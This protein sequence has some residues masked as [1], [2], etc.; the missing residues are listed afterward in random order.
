ML[1]LG[2]KLA[3]IFLLFFWETFSKFEGDCNCEVAAILNLLAFFLGRLMK[4]GD[5]PCFS[6]LL[7]LSSRIMFTVFL[8]LIDC[9]KSEPFATPLIGCPVHPRVFLGI[10]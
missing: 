3:L 10:S 7:S 5:L 2:L 1:A 6:L 4:E 8:L 9:L